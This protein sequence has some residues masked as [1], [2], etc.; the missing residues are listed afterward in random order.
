MPLSPLCPRSARLIPIAA[1]ALCAAAASAQSSAITSGS[2]KLLLTGG[3]S[4][5]DGAAGGGLTPWAVTGSYATRNEVGGTAFATRVKTQGYALTTAGVALSFDDR[6]EL[7]AARQSFDTGA[8]GETLGLPGLRLRQD[9]LGIKVR[10]VGDAVLDSDRWWPQLAAG[11]LIK[12]SDAGA[13]APILASLGASD[14][15]TDVYLSATKLLLA[16]GVLIN[17]TLRSTKAN[18]NG[19][20]GFGGTEHPGRRW[21]PEISLAKLLRKDVAIGV[22]WRR[23]PDNL[24]PSNLGAALKEDDWADLFV[25]WAPNKHLSLTAAYV[26]LGRIV[27]GFAPK[28]QTGGYL[29]VQLA[30]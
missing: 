15:G 22:E 1:L 18:Q 8:T 19:L 27:P 25:A 10:L 26:D 24:N 23:K 16:P 30:Y 17:L 11:V 9:I 2:G 29:S 7:S 6:V 3:V 28:R 12:R 5:I 21:M 4:S 13:L 14:A 20:L